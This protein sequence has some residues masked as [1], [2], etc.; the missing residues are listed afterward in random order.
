MSPDRLIEAI[1]KMT[2]SQKLKT[3]GYILGKLTTSPNDIARAFKPVD[4]TATTWADVGKVLK[5]F[6][7]NQTDTKITVE[8]I[9]GKGNIINLLKHLGHINWCCSSGSSRELKLSVDGDGSAF[10]RARVKGAP[11]LISQLMKDP[12]VWDK[13]GDPAHVYLD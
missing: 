2:T 5:K 8:I 12:K 6:G 1:P 3:H 10:I 11:K 7:F 13:N 9:G 4:T